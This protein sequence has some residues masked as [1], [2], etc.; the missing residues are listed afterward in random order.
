MASSNMLAVG[1]IKT[2]VPPSLLPAS[3]Q[4][5]IFACTFFALVKP[6]AGIADPRPIYTAPL[7]HRH[8]REKG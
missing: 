2:S 1:I 8:G 4:V 5:V 7:I 6:C 3:P